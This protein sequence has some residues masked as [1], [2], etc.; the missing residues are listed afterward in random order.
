MGLQEN[1]GLCTLRHLRADGV[2]PAALGE[3]LTDPRVSS[4][5]ASLTQD[6]INGQ[7]RLFAHAHQFET[8]SGK[9]REIEYIGVAGK[10]IREVATEFDKVVIATLIAP[11]TDES[12]SPPYD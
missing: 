3:D 9:R 5:L 4:L 10:T 6:I 8:V 1:I 7:D 11:L 12:D 2:W